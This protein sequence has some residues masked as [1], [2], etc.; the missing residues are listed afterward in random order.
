[1]VLLFFEIHV[2]F[3]LLRRIIDYY[4]FMFPLV[5]KIHRNLK[6]KIEAQGR[7]LGRIAAEYQNRTTSRR[8]RKSLSLQST[9]S[10]CE[11]S[12][13]NAKE[14]ERDL[15]AERIEMESADH[16]E[17]ILARKRPR[18]VEDNNNVFTP[19]PTSEVTN[20]DPYNQNLFL[21]EEE[22]SKQSASDV[23]FPWNIITCPSP[24]IASYF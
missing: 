20:S 7:F 3:L 21:A 13:S 10:L 16:R 15:E 19:P 1:M 17:I 2:L 4:Q 5:L 22:I 9:P 14:T 6:L 18:V 8:T 23:I 24:L 12:E 11:E